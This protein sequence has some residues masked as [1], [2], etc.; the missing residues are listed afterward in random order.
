VDDDEI[1]TQE[2]QFPM[3]G[4]VSG[5]EIGLEDLNKSTAVGDPS[6]FPTN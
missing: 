3:L 2:F 4:C 1:K 6:E 5:L